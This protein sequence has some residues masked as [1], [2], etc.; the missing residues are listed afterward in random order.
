[1]PILRN[2]RH[3]QFAQLVVSG[4]TPSAAYVYAGFSK[5][6]ASASAT[7]L[8][9]SANVRARV[10]ELQATVSQ[11]AITRASVDR[12]YVV[13]A[14]KENAERALQREPVRDSRGN[15]TG[16][17][18]YAGAVANRALEL[19]GKELGMFVDRIPHTGA[20]GGPVR[21]M[22]YSKLSLQQLEQLE[23]LLMLAM[24]ETPR[25]AVPQ[26]PIVPATPTVDPPA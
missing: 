9:K 12:Q 21:T 22:D 4:K 3:E 6:G 18:V 2:P 10:E 16:E 15:E 24:G 8:L 13:A 26:P 17:Y 1:M 25:A 5:A 19:L 20:D 11:A 23:Y 7:R 14:L